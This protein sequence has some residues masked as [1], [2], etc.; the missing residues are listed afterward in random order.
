VGLTDAAAVRVLADAGLL[1]RDPSA[2]VF[3]SVDVV[4]RNRSLHLRLP[5]GTGFVLKQA[6]R[7]DRSDLANEA[8]VLRALQACDGAGV[9]RVAAGL[10]A[11]D[12]ARMVLVTELLAGSVDLRRW[13][14]GARA[15]PRWVGAG[16]GGALAWLHGV[17]P[18]SNGV[19]PLRRCDPF[20]L[21]LHRPAL[22]RFGDLSA[23]NLRLI[24]IV[25]A[26][27]VLTE[28]LDDLRQA[29]EPSVPIHADVRLDNVMVR[30]GRGI[31]QVRL[32]DWEL[33]GLGDPA[34][35]V[36]AALAM[37]VEAWIWSIPFVGDGDAL[38]AGAAAARRP[39]RTMH[40]VLRELWNAYARTCALPG[41]GA[42]ALLRRSV[43]FAAARLLQA[44]FESAAE[45]FELSG[46]AVLLAQVAAN[47]AEAPDLAAARLLGLGTPGPERVP[48]GILV[49]GARA[50][51]AGPP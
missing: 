13:L 29:W 14:D 23:G 36:G 8:A 43:R 17:R 50:F 27:P 11:F 9:S 39:I 33:A 38:D 4:R 34:F 30:A 44:A 35:D 40:A 42:A 15:L 1:S 46:H 47:L 16:I 6:R 37:F 26:T 22:E 32:V 41:T 25:Q 2:H 49:Q 48:A 31:R 19:G 51:R 28:L 12:P 5:D 3:T 45:S 24:R 20:V 18:A 21:R 7:P 10:L